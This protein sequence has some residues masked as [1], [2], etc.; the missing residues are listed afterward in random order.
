MIPFVLHR[1]IAQC[2]QKVNG[3]LSHQV[4]K[5]LN[6]DQGKS[7]GSKGDLIALK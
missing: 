6:L 5:F 7:K 1:N 3:E 4:G 2:A